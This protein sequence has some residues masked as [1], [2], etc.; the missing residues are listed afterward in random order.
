M[1][2]DSLRTK[3]F[4][5]TYRMMRS[6]KRIPS[7]FTDFD[8]SGTENWQPHT[9]EN[10]IVLPQPKNTFLTAYDPLESL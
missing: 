6:K 8:N 3:T 7:L 4:I 5:E 2:A 1:D 10:N 9:N